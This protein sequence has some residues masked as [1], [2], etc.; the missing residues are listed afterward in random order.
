MMSIH[1][2]NKYLLTTC[3]H[4]P[5]SLPEIRRNKLSEI[6]TFEEIKLEK[7]LLDFQ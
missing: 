5:S 7:D 1:L 2:L 6:F 3:H 4:N